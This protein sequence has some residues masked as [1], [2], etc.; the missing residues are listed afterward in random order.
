GRKRLRLSVA[1]AST[2]SPEGWWVTRLHAVG[3]FVVG[4]GFWAD[5]EGQP[6]FRWGPLPLEGVG[7]WLESVEGF[8]GPAVMDGAGVPVEIPL[9][10]LGQVTIG[11]RDTR[12]EGERGRP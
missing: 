10:R 12:L 1:Q 7:R 3:A 6:R 5:S 2:A 9:L 11:P 4:A 8:R